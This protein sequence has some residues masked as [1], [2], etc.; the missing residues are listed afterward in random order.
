MLGIKLGIFSELDAAAAAEEDTAAFYG[1]RGVWGGGADSG[2]YDYNIIDYVTIATTSNATDFGD[3]TVGRYRSAAC[4]NGTRGVFGGGY[5]STNTIDYV[6]IAT[7]SDAT[8]F[9]DL[10]VKRSN[11]SACS[12]G[13]KGVFGGGL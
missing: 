5:S 3:L 12:D 8:D 11:L 7:P 4:S 2:T 13:T 1:G 10:T 9:G 6:T